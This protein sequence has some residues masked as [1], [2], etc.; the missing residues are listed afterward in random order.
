MLAPG[1]TSF[2]PE[3]GT[4]MDIKKWVG[5][6]LGFFRACPLDDPSILLFIV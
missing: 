1:F 4:A 6:R 3:D 2:N 5:C